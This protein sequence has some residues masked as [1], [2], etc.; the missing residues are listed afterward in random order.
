MSISYHQFL[1]ISVPK[2]L[3]YHFFISNP[4][5]ILLLLN[6]EN[7][8][9]RL[10]HLLYNSYSKSPIPQSISNSITRGCLKI[11]PNFICPILTVLQY[12]SF[13]SIYSFSSKPPFWNKRCFIVRSWFSFLFSP[14]TSL[15]WHLCYAPNIM[16]YLLFSPSKSSFLILLNIVHTPVLKMLLFSNLYL[17]FKINFKHK[18]L[19]MTFLA[20]TFK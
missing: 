8:F 17:S 15:L 18:P 5:T 20:L 7:L 16:H 12:Y 9:P 3:L 13:N 2:Y 10:S 14:Y 4:T 1:L 6:P 19:I 11:G